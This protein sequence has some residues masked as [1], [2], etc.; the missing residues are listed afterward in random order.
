MILERFNSS[1]DVFNLLNLRAHFAFK[2]E[3]SVGFLLGSIPKGKDSH[4][5]I[6]AMQIH[7]PCIGHIGAYLY[8]QLPRRFTEP[9]ILRQL[10][11]ATFSELGIPADET[12][13]LHYSESS[14]GITMDQRASRERL[15]DTI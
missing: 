14:K 13:E 9:D 7:H 3:T 12:Y 4:I 10:C 1:R 5:V 15:T 8:V 11:E 2:S 6:G